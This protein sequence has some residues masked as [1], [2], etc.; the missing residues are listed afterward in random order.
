MTLS[1]LHPRGWFTPAAPMSG[2]GCFLCL[3]HG[4]GERQV[5]ISHERV[6]ETDDLGPAPTADDISLGDQIQA[7]DTAL[8]RAIAGT[9]TWPS[10][11]TGQWNA[12]EREVVCLLAA[13]ET[14]RGLVE[15]PLVDPDDVAAAELVDETLRKLEASS[16]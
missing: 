4:P 3:V 1:S 15:L 13:L 14:L 16:A 12:D 6:S 9:A 10:D 2:P 11:S 8:A 7:V 5:N